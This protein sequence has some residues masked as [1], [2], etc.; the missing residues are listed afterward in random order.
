MLQDHIACQDIKGSSRGHRSII[1]VED[2][3]FAVVVV[4]GEIAGN[5][6][7]TVRGWVEVRHGEDNLIGIIVRYG[8]VDISMVARCVRGSGCLRERAATAVRMMR[9]AFLVKSDLMTNLL[10][11]STIPH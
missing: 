8:I 6:G 4:H 11:C 9:L 10:L 3:P 2:G 1:F 5:V 7:A